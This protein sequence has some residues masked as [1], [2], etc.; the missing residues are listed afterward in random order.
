M[1]SPLCLLAALCVGLSKSGFSGVGLIT[2]ALMADIFPS[3]QSTGILLPLLIFGDLC[4]VQ[5]FKKHT[6]WREILKLLPP[7]L[8]GVTAGFFLMR[9]IPDERFRPILGWMLLLTVLVQIARTA[10]QRLGESLPQ[11]RLVVW[12]IGIWAGI[13]TMV[14]NAA[15]PIFG[16]YLLGLA[17]PKEQMVGTSAW[18]FLIVNVLKLP[19]SAGL[20]LLNGST[21]Q[22]DLMLA[23]VVILGTV[24]GRLLLGKIPQKL[25]EALLLCT[26]TATALKLIL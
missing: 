6:I 8:L 18:F 26:A 21:L 1:P 3:R 2:V 19:F 10:N 13:A 9:T 14:A 20:G 22:L 16:I 17:L 7:T 4:A 24:T 5:A 25:F 12:F 15:G 23:P 11:G